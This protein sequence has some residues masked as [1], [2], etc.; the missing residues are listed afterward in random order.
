MQLDPVDV[1]RAVYAAWNAGEWGIEHF[2]PNVE[3]ELTSEGSVDQAGAAQGRDALLS[4][5]RRFWEAWEP[6][7]RWEI[8]ELERAGG[9]HVLACGRLRARGRSSGIEVSTPVFHA[10]TV[11]EGV[12]ERLVVCDDRA[13]ALASI[14]G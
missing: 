12:V 5:W 1:V 9:N 7:A 4:Y 10:W 8:Q 3:W 14:A 11:S 6:G 13:A 2:H